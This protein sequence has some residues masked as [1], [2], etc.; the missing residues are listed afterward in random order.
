MTGPIRQVIRKTPA[1]RTPRS[2][3]HHAIWCEFQPAWGAITRA[4]ERHGCGLRAVYTRL[5]KGQLIVGPD[6][7]IVAAT[8]ISS[9][10]ADHDKSIPLTAEGSPATARRTNDD[11]PM[12][13]SR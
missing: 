2:G 1:E 3:R 4:A 13:V 8:T 10:S 9:L 7:E 6:G 5:A 11:A 12:R